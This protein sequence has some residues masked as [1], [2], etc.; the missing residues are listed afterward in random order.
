MFTLTPQRLKSRTRFNA[1]RLVTGCKYWTHSLS[2]LWY[3]K[4]GAIPSSRCMIWSQSA[5]SKVWGNVRRKVFSHTAPAFWINLQDDLTQ[6]GSSQQTQWSRTL[7]NTIKLDALRWLV[8]WCYKIKTD[9]KDNFQPSNRQTTVTP[10]LLTAW[11]RSHQ[12]K[13]LPISF[14]ICTLKH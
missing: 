2:I 1:L 10:L 9:L 7:L 14:S 5:D 4:N 12:M 8:V 13:N 3:K 6:K 11:V